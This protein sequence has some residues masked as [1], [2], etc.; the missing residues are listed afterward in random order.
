MPL[1]RQHVDVRLGPLDTHQDAKTAP[2]GVME[3]V[4]NATREKTG[5][6]VKRTGRS[7]LSTDAFGTGI[8]FPNTYQ[9][10]NY[11]NQLIRLKTISDDVSGGGILQAYNPAANL[12]STSATLTTANTKGIGTHMRDA[13][14]SQLHPIYGADSVPANPDIA[15]IPGTT[16][17]VCVFDSSTNSGTII[18]VVFDSA[19]NQVLRSRSFLGYRPKAQSDGL[20]TVLVGYLTAGF[21]NTR[22]WVAA[23]INAGPTVA[24]LAAIPTISGAA[25]HDMQAYGTDIMAA[26]LTTTPGVAIINLSTGNSTTVP[27]GGGAPDAD[28]SLGWLKDFGGAGICILGTASTTTSSVLAHVYTPGTGFV[29]PTH[30]VT[31]VLETPIAAGYT[32]ANICGFT[33][34]SSG[35]GNFVCLYDYMYAPTSAFN[36]FNRLRVARRSGVTITTGLDLIRSVS[37]RSKV[38][39]ANGRNYVMLAYDETVEGSI[40]AEQASNQN[41]YFGFEVSSDPLSGPPQNR[42]PI[43][44][45]AT[46]TAN[47]RTETNTGLTDVVVNGSSYY[48]GFIIQRNVSAESFSTADTAPRLVLAGVS[49]GKITYNSTLVGRCVEFAD[50]LILPLGLLSQF[51]GRQLYELGFNLMPGP[52]IG[53]SETATAG[54]FLTAGEEYFWAWV[55]RRVDAVGRTHRGAPWYTPYGT[56]PVAPNLTLNWEVVTLKLTGRETSSPLISPDDDMA[57]E[58]YRTLGNGQVFQLVNHQINNRTVD[59]STISDADPDS[60]VALATQLYTTGDVLENVSPPQLRCLTVH[61][62]RL[63]GVNADDL[64]EVWYSKPDAVGEGPGFNDV[65]TFR[66]PEDITAMASMDDKLVLFSS[67]SIFVVTGD[68]PN[69]L[70]E[71]TFPPP[72]RVVSGV[73]CLL[74]RSVVYTPDGLWFH[75]PKGIYLLARGLD[76]IFAGAP[77]KDYTDG[78]TTLD[79]IH[80]KGKNQ[81]RFYQNTGNALVYDYHFKEWWLWT[82]QADRAMAQVGDEVYTAKN[83]TPGEVFRDN[84]SVYTDNGVGYRFLLGAS[85]IATGGISG[86]QRLYEVQIVGQFAGACFARMSMFY[87]YLDTVA[88]SRD[89]VTAP[90]VPFNFSLRVARQ[91]CA[92]FKVQVMDDDGS[93]GVVTTAGFRFSGIGLDV[94]VK[95]ALNKLAS[96]KRMT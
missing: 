53:S 51:D 73:G 8:Y 94:G 47:G 15:F 69:N 36:T 23:S 96:A 54:G 82:G 38:W 9:L 64:Q 84:E 7:V 5:E 77:V 31:H 22:T 30:V 10:A 1:Q 17:A 76:A 79:A 26:F 39:L 18:E 14:A 66:C 50:S 56:S 91:K 11:K 92:A 33:T 25:R 42:C 55:Y 52:P 71:N 6:Y 20:T 44:K 65:L 95:A 93:G 85:W 12:W 48:G 74:P 35:T 86:F 67:E 88:E 45:M 83:V 43:L 13:L 78:A 59:T 3:V 60:S 19:T 80:V 40:S 70:G 89:V 24:S 58:M 57:I 49:V 21:Y 62:E 27:P 46:G 16:Y 37:L 63:F 28:Q 87:D 81:V 29:P 4:Q 90:S 61:R 75:S 68:G 41:A 34:N 2:V 32:V 72:Q